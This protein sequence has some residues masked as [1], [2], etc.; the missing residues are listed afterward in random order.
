MNRVIHHIPSQ[1]PSS[2]IVLH[3]VKG[4]K[5]VPPEFADDPDLYY[6]IQASMADS[7][8]NMDIV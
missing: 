5:T 4:N 7:N 1:Q 2:T 3:K 8:D 6:A